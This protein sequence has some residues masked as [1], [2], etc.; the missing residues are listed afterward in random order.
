MHPILA[1]LLVPAAFA[2]ADI[3]PPDSAPP[4]G[5]PETELVVN[6]AAGLI[7][8][9]PGA[10]IG[11][12]TTIAPRG[13]FQARI[14]ATLFG[15]APTDGVATPI[16]GFVEL[17]LAGT[18]KTGP[19][20]RVGLS[21]TGETLLVSEKEQEC[22]GGSGCRW[23]VTAP[24]GPGL[25][26]L[27]W[28]PGVRWSRRSDSGAGIDLNVAPQV[29]F[30]HD[31]GVPLLRIDLDVIRPSGWVYGLETNRF[32]AMATVGKRL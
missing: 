1:A 17:E 24:L 23:W 8:Y 12:D 20:S 18:L 22:G 30:N 3:S 16:A 27:S 10:G 28:A 6:A 2:A 32:G 5:G 14:D 4:S 25:A 13:A 15:R 9:V 19:R 31:M 11:L 26:V 21:V 7:T 29:A